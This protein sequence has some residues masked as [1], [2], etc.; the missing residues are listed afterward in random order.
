[1]RVGFRID[2]TGIAVAGAATNAWA[3]LPIPLVKHYAKR[4]VKRLQT[5]PREIIAQLL[6]TRLVT[7]CEIRER[8]AA[9]RLSGIFAI[10]AVD[11]INA[12]SLGVIRLQFIV[13]NRPGRRDPTGM[14]Y[15]AEILFAETE[16]RRAI[17]FGV[18]TDVI[19]GVWMQLAAVRVAP[20]F[21]RVVAAMCIHLQ[22]I[23]ILF[24]ARNKWTAFEQ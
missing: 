2:Q 21:F 17:K 4:R 5:K 7:D 18:S 13:R 8:A 6:D 1:M 19:I 14:F 10:F 16:Q 12:F 22:G 23:P 11:M 9:M 15:L 20:K 24:L 3:L